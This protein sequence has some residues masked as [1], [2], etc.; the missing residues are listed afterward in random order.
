MISE[1][2]DDKT[3]IV[4][5]AFSPS[6]SLNINARAFRVYMNMHEY[7]FTKYLIYSRA[8]LN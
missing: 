8:I 6:L 2:A 5:A 1:I 4:S 3:V 7:I